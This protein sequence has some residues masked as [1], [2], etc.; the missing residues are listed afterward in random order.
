ML[1]QITYIYGR[2]NSFDLSMTEEYQNLIRFIAFLE[3]EE[4][5]ENLKNIFEDFIGQKNMLFFDA[6]ELK[7]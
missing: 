7:M 5:E 1:E 2:K 4:M 3:K 6:K